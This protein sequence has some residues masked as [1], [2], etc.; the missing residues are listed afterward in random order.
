MLPA[1][2][3]LL[4]GCVLFQVT[5]SEPAAPQAEVRVD[6]KD[7]VL[8]QRQILLFGQIDQRAAERTIQKL[9]YLESKSHEPI[10]LYLQTP[11][12]EFKHAMAVEKIMGLLKSPVN[13]Y[14]MSECN[15][16]GVVLLAAGTGKR[17]AFRGTMVILHGLKVSGRRP[18]PG[19]LERC[20]EAYTQFWRQKARLPE[21][22]LPLPPNVMHILSAEQ[23]LEYG[24]VDEVVGK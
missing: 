18:P 12:G 17:R 9:L 14:A 15:S 22:W 4:Q 20:Q 8:N 5:S 16:G 23:A 3:A 21:S 10:D 19:F 1:L 7:P 6:S 13:T 2:G 24:V 11:G